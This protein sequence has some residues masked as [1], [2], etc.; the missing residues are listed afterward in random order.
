VV[1]G[2]GVAHLAAYGDVQSQIWL[3]A[4]FG[5]HVASCG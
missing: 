3:Q 5:S 2:G 4:K 1:G